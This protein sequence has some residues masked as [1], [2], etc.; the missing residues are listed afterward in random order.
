MSHTPGPW[1]VG[2]PTGLV[3]QVSIE[4]SIGCVYGA[5]EEVQA[6]ANLVAASPELYAAL[7]SALPIL[8]IDSLTY[9]QAQTALEKARGLS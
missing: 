3:N 4:P 1:R 7:E 5:A 9:A 6:N 2:G 8:W